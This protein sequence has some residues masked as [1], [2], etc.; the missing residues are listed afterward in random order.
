[1]I[2]QLGFSRTQAEQRDFVTAEDIAKKKLFLP[3]VKTK[4]DW[5]EFKEKFL[6]QVALIPLDCGMNLR[7]FMIAHYVKLVV[8]L[9]DWLGEHMSSGVDAPVNIP[10]PPAKP[11]LPLAPID[12]AKLNSVRNYVFNRM[13]GGAGKLVA[14]HADDSLCQLWEFCDYVLGIRTKA[15]ETH[16]ET[17]FRN[18]KMKENDDVKEY[19]T[20]KLAKARELQ[21]TIHPST[22][23]NNMMNMM[24]QCLPGKWSHLSAHM[25]THRPATLKELRDTVV[26][27]QA[28]QKFQEGHELGG[29]APKQNSAPTT[30]NAPVAGANLVSEG[31]ADEVNSAFLVGK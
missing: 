21:N 17:K 31:A 7:D 4:E 3:I 2:A 30:I 18:E 25:A 11:I 5:G 23:K 22:L 10:S 20:K 6:A 26:N 24:I 1:M 9:I 13:Q 12:V 28:Q 15:G 29:A 19:F 16:E 14:G 8:Y 27:W